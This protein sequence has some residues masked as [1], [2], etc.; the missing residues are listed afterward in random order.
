MKQNNHT[1][2]I[3]RKAQVVTRAVRLRHH[4]RSDYICSM[5]FSDGMQWIC[6]EHNYGWESWYFHILSTW[7]LDITWQIQC[8]VTPFMIHTNPYTTTLQEIVRPLLMNRSSYTPG[9]S[10]VVSKYLD[11]QHH[12]WPKRALWHRIEMHPHWKTGLI[13]QHQLEHHKSQCHRMPLHINT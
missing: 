4:S 8:A 11:E 6:C 5:P 1:G 2:R 10:K 12:L 13:A 3:D 7:P 9:V